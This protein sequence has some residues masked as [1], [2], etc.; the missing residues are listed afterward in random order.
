MPK[1]K[2]WTKEEIEYL[3]A[4]YQKMSHQ[5]MAANLENRTVKAVKA[6]CKIARFINPKYKWTAQKVE[7]LKAKYPGTKSKILAKEL[8]CSL[9]TLYNKAYSL[10][11]KKN[12]EFLKSEE[13][14]RLTKGKVI[15]YN[16][17]FKKGRIPWNKDKKGFMGA[18]ITSF[19]PGQRPHNSA[20]IGTESVIDGYTTV[21]VGEP[22]IW[23][24]KHRLVWE[25]NNGEIPQG[26]AI[27]FKDGNLSNFA[28]E[29]L[30]MISRKELRI[31][32][33]IHNKYTPELRSVINTLG[34][35]KRKI[36]K[37]KEKINAQK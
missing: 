31:R 28:V 35:L 12:E 18:N 5:D 33:S 37:R 20:P 4:N 26:Q 7:I 3:K 13:C 27:I 1:G 25:Q 2:G 15:G 14:G 22:N 32:N 11:L 9:Y 6:R 19:Q 36:N 24:W 16:T 17:Q 10:D 23:K 30:E 8:G 29:N 21:K 34:S